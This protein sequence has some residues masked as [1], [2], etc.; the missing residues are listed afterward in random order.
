MKFVLFVPLLLLA[1]SPVC[2][3]EPALKMEVFTHGIRFPLKRF[4]LV[5]QGKYLA[6]VLFLDYKANDEGEFIN[7]KNFTFA[8][9]AWQEEK[10]GEIGYRSLTTWQRLVGVIGMHTPP[11]SRIKPLE[12]SGLTLVAHPGFDGEHCAYVYFGKSLAKPDPTIK[13]APTPWRTIEEVN[14]KDPRLK[15]YGPGSPELKVKIDELWK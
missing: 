9:G 15:W 1:W 13:L 5:S 12:L 7:Y 11:I 10:G 14:L 6:A 2:A 3:S 4:L 8:R